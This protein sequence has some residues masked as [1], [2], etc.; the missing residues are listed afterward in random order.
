[1]QWFSRPHS[2]ALAVRGQGR[3]VLWSK[4]GWLLGYW[5]ILG[6]HFAA[7]VPESSSHAHPWC[8]ASTARRGSEHWPKNSYQ[9]RAWD[10][11]KNEWNLP[12]EGSENP[13]ELRSSKESI[14]LQM[15]R[16]LWILR[17]EY[18][19][20]KFAKVKQAVK[21]YESLFKIKNTFFKM[22]FV[23]TMVILTFL[24]EM[25]CEKG[26]YYAKN[27]SSRF[28]NWISRCKNS[29]NTFFWTFF[30]SIKIK[31]LHFSPLNRFTNLLKT[32]YL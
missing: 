20:V 28:V 29:K 12:F 11:G 18:S 5:A 27:G 7:S 26:V 2:H 1:M 16:V 15:P 21:I 4:V 22:K 31:N 8:D 24:S 19:Y 14:C 23:C 3:P 17:C 25:F 13:F 6:D 30:R 32:P 9:T 10:A